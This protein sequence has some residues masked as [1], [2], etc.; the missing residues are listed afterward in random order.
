[1]EQRHFVRLR[2]DPTSV[3]SALRANFDPTSRG[4]PVI[5]HRAKPKTVS[6]ANAQLHGDGDIS[7]SMVAAVEI[8]TLPTGLGCDDPSSQ[9][10]ATVQYKLY[11]T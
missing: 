11:P 2:S 5:S 9:P 1:M 8:T 4:G 3:G 7:T 6:L 10:G